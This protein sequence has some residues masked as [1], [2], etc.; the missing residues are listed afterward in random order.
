[1]QKFYPDYDAIHSFTLSLD[2]HQNEVQC[3]FCLKNDQFISHGVVYKQHSITDKEKVGK[4]IFCS[5]R[6]GRSGCGR[7]FQLYIACKLPFFQYGAAHLFV[8]ISSLLANMT[9][10]ESYIKATKQ[11]EIEPRNA[12]RWLNKL[13]IKLM[14]YRT[15]L[16]VRIEHNLSQLK[17]R[18]IRLLHLLSTF[19][20]LFLTNN[21]NHCSKFQLT[22][23]KAFI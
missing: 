1:M 17:P 7:T 15:F 4:R 8:F 6:Y 12:W 16:K 19:T 9:I 20:R 13:M 10:A 23:Q 11:S 2:Y 21:D 18:T 14:D 3:G 22:Q 5:N